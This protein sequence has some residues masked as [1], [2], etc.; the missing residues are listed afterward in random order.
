MD[1]FL[2]HCTT[3]VVVRFHLMVSFLVDIAVTVT[4][5]LPHWFTA[6]LTLPSPSLQLHHCSPVCSVVEHSTGKPMEM[7]KTPIPVPTSTQ[8][9]VQNPPAHPH[10]LIPSPSPTPTHCLALTPISPSHPHLHLHTHLPLHA[11]AAS[12]Y[13]TY[14]PT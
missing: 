2:S 3:S 4:H 1:S 7:G 10:A 8:V 11:L 12:C 5:T 14:A 9:Q 13:L 6:S